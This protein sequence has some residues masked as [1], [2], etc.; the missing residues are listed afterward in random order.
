MRRRDLSDEEHALWGRAVRDVKPA[1]RRAT[2]LGKKGPAP[3]PS[4]RT[5]RLQASDA[6]AERRT[7]KILG[8]GDPAMDRAAKS[9]RIAVE[10]SLDLHGLSQAEAH[11]RLLRFL[12]SAAEDGMRLALIITGKGR[13]GAGEKRGVIRARFLDWV[14][15]PPIR[16][17]VSRVSPAGPRD[18][19]GGAFYVF[20]KRRGAGKSPRP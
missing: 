1:E 14:E 4:R 7:H 13:V 3:A 2:S 20:L 17:I 9:R 12:Q 19:G 18:G 5:P 16:S 11:R 8:G 6:T 10:R 15:A